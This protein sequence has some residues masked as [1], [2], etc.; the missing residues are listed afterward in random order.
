MD[1]RQLPR[2]P[3]DEPN[4]DPATRAFNRLEGEMA[5]MRRAVEH[6]ATEKA[7]I[8]IPD[9]SSTLG[10]IAAR[11]VAIEGKP[12]M[13]MTPEDMA[14]RIAAAATAAR[15]EDRAALA[16][17]RQQQ[18]EAAQALR[19]LVGTASTTGE[20]H[21]YLKWAAGGGMLAGMLLW[22][23]MPGVILRTLPESWH[24]PESMAAHIIG[25]PSLMEAGSRMMQAGDADAW[26][27]IVAAVEMRRDNRDA[28]AACE[29]TAAK[30]GK[31]VRCEINIRAPG[32]DDP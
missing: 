19:S 1:D 25:A 28:I 20:Q 23:I 13:Q 6:L 3:Y 16:G 9:Y 27:A 2:L 10:E 24:M 4:P 17:A 29:R 8:D 26:N 30:A 31:G 21:R 22:S 32:R 15:R 11:L 5:L 18:D 12:A 14:A 7:E